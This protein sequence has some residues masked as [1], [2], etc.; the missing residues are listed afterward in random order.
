M[1]LVL[2]FIILVLERPSFLE[3]HM[4]T[5]EVMKYYGIEVLRIFNWHANFEASLECDLCISNI[6]DSVSS[7]AG[8]T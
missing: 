2:S 5:R 1:V 4:K 8:V 3:K 6:L 7:R